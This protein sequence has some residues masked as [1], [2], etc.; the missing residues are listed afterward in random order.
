VWIL[1][2][3]D[4]VVPSCCDRDNAVVAVVKLRQIILEVRGCQE[5]SSAG[6]SAVLQYAQVGRRSSSSEGAS[7][8]WCNDGE[9]LKESL[10][11]VGVAP[12]ARP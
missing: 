8:G 10:A 3:C 11:H 1:R 4:C 12:L 6:E 5:L 2:R 7:V 9:R